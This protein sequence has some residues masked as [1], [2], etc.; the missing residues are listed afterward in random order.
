MDTG[1][2]ATDI[3]ELN[4]SQRMLITSN[5]KI[6]LD[7]ILTLRHFVVQF[8]YAGYVSRY[9]EIKN[10]QDVNAIL[11]KFKLTLLKKE[12]DKVKPKS[13]IVIGMHFDDIKHMASSA[14]I[15]H[16]V[17]SRIMEG[18][19]SVCVTNDAV[20]EISP[21][22]FVTDIHNTT[23]ASERNDIITKITNNSGNHK[24]SVAAPDGTYYM[25]AHVLERVRDRFPHTKTWGI[26]AMTKYTIK[27]FCASKVTFITNHG[28]KYV[29]KGK[30][31][32]VVNLKGVIV[33]VIP[34]TKDFL[35]YAECYKQSGAKIPSWLVSKNAMVIREDIVIKFSQAGV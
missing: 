25:Y 32:F 6:G 28:E 35:L 8:N 11:D 13:T 27:Q 33:T 14:G 21:E 15:M 30:M 16:K 4:D 12:Q 1:L 20:C 19:P 31:T 34:T 7:T 24:N 2:K 26:T 23:D 5:G 17:S 18:L 29:I 10:P 9:Q 22:G 3:K